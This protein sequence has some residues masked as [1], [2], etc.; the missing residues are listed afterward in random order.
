MALFHWLLQS[1][2]VPDVQLA[3][4]PAK[5]SLQDMR[6]Y[7]TDSDYQLPKD[8]EED[9]RLNFQH[10]ALYYAIGNHYVAPLLPP[11]LTVLDVGTGT[12]IWAQEIARL[13]PTALVVGVDIA[14]SSFKP[15]AQGNCLLRVG[16]VLKGLPFPDEFFSFTH[17]RLLVTGIPGS[18]WPDAVRELVRVTRPGGWV[19][20]LELSGGPSGG[21]ATDRL[22]EVVNTGL[23]KAL[24]F[25]PEV[26]RHLDDVLRQAGLENVEMHE[27]RMPVGAWAGRIGEMMKRD[28][29]GVLTALRGPVCHQTGVAI[30]EYNKLVQANADEWETHRSSSLFYATFGKKAYS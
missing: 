18:R 12:G 29:L 14:D 24:G 15:P 10:Y 2:K 8:E 11:L 23:N 9:L 22:A 4:S 17:Q 7:L 25:D 16:N 13:F 19:E 27:I 21:P 28:Y 30:D 5:T 1:K 26:I 6:S 3:Q 20:L